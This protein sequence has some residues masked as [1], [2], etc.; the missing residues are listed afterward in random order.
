M[1]ASQQSYS[2]RCDHHQN[3]NKS[4]L[5]EPFL[6]QADGVLYQAKTSGHNRVIYAGAVLRGV[7]AD[8]RLCRRFKK[9]RKELTRVSIENEY[10]DWK[11]ASTSSIDSLAKRPDSGQLLGFVGEQSFG[12]LKRGIKIHRSGDEREAT[13]KMFIQDG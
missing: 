3:W 1:G 5:I 2:R 11:S 6:K 4:T 13:C 8:A 12:F 10:L 7:I 9:K